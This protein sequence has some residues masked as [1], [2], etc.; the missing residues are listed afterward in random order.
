M[1]SA[2]HAR[3]FTV[4]TRPRQRANSAA[5]PQRHLQPSMLTFRQHLR[6]LPMKPIIFYS[7]RA[8]SITTPALA[9]SGTLYNLPPYG[10]APY[11]QQS[12][13]RQMPATV[14]SPREFAP[15]SLSWSGSMLAATSGCSAATSA[16]LLSSPPAAA[17]LSEPALRGA[18]Q[19]AYLVACE[20]A[21]GLDADRRRKT[22]IYFGPEG[23]CFRAASQPTFRRRWRPNDGGVE[24]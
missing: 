3:G 22:L 4:S 6:M 24:T 21:R 13:D 17:R 8:L 7:V 10:D 16:I 14:G 18:I 15:S 1:R 9:Q 5:R 19:A 23:P 2:C 20:T 12:Y 11:L